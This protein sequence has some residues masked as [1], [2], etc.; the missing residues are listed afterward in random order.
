M[1]FELD[2]DKRGGLTGEAGVGIAPLTERRT[3][4]RGRGRKTR[5][6]CV[7]RTGEDEGGER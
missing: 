2:L 3:I 6:F 7:A 1:I 4:S 5:P